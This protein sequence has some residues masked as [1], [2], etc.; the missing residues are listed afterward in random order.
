[1]PILTRAE[2]QIIYGEDY[3]EHLSGEEKRNIELNETE[4]DN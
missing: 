1:M 2:A 4:E 3:W